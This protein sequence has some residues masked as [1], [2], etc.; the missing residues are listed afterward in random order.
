MFAENCAAIGRFGDRVLTSICIGS[1]V[2][3]GVQ[4]GLNTC[5][6]S[7]V[8]RT[9]LKLSME[10]V[11]MSHLG[12]SLPTSAMFVPAAADAGL[13]ERQSFRFDYGSSRSNRTSRA[14]STGGQAY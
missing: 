13:C 14:S 1:R 11:P 3:L 7:S 4:Y 10:P 9:F 2:W 5:D 8:Y 6:H 12:L